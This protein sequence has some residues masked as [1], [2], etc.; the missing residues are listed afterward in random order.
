M[1][2]AICKKKIIWKLGIEMSANSVKQK[3]I[4]FYANEKA[5]IA[6]VDR[7]TQ[8]K[9]G[10]KVRFTLKK[11]ESGFDEYTLSVRDGEMFIQ[12][13]SGSAG[14]VALNAYLKKYCHYYYG[15]LTQSGVLPDALPDTKEDIC[16]SSVFD[17]R[18]AFNYCTFGYS[19]AFNTWEDWEK[20]TDYL[21]LAGYNLVLNPIGNE[22]V[23]V[24][25][26]QEF[27]YTKE[28]TMAYISSPNYLP[29]Q[30]MMNLSAFESCAFDE[31][32]IQQQEISKKFN[33]KLK[34]FGMSAV[35]PGYCGAVPDDFL[36]KNPDV[37]VYEQGKWAGFVRPSIL[38]AENAIF[39]KIAVRYYEL[40]NELLHAYDMHYY[41]TDPF[42]EGGKKDG[43]K[44][45]E[46]AKKVLD[47][48]RSVDDDAV[49]CLQGWN[50][51]PD[52]A[53]LSTIE[54]EHALIMNL[55]ADIDPDG[56]DDF[57]GYPH[58]YCVVNNFGG[59]YAMRG[60]A[61]KT[62][63]IPHGMALSD[64]SSCVGVGVMPEGVECDEILFDIIAEISINQQLKPMQAFLREYITARY[65]TCT[66]V[67][68]KAYKLLI[69][70]VY[71]QD[72]VRY[73]HESGLMAYPH[74]EV[75]RVCRY[76]GASLVEDNSH[77]VD[78]AKALLSVWEECKD[79]ESYRTDIVAVCRQLIA[80]ESWK[81]IYAFNQAYKDGDKQTFEKN[82]TAFLKLFPLQE[83]IVDC[84]KQLNLQ[85]YLDKAICR[86]NTNE[87]KRAL[88][89]NAK[90][91]ITLWG[92]D[93]DSI[94]VHDYAPRE[95]GDML[96]DFYK[97]RWERYLSR[98]RVS[99]ETGE[100]MAEYNRY[101]YENAFIKDEKEYAREI[102][103]Q[104]YGAAK[105]ILYLY[106]KGE[107]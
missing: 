71:T 80:N 37:K 30:W 46:Y 95:Y 64:T 91:L 77:L 90:R 23:W 103:C 74:L 50:E 85:G 19:Y 88:R 52:R 102:S 83:A 61:E 36:K 105:N 82:A 66:P 58:I 60:S 6:F 96:R 63:R 2:I 43:I 4:P 93:A 79:R 62:Y 40:Q 78:I 48:M 34:A 84:D 21:I 97:P 106:E 89:E 16:G 13:T 76:A 65:G 18:Y 55:H 70:K 3:N 24:A 53:L 10:K 28:E 12:A 27:G 47:A 104:L 59:E 101:I 9:Y 26:L 15:I 41:S 45:E 14:G 68:E 32:Y 38:S 72:I 39:E 20:I 17:Y 35:M 87:K 31:W 56:G 54:K 42:H 107:L 11:S 69:E 99:L 44:I 22:C 67:L 98:A 5:F 86:G 92:L 81:Y 1:Q 8:G 73:P 94:F 57:L 7:V 100:P 33:A 25:L 75:N 51:N 49:W 29:W